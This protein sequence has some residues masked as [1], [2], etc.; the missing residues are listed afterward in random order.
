[1]AKKSGR[2]NDGEDQDNT[3]GLRIP[4]IL[5]VPVGLCVG[6]MVGDVLGAALG[7]VIGV[8]LWRSRA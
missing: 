3:G 7:A 8:F 2:N 5:M 1:M 4:A 6:W